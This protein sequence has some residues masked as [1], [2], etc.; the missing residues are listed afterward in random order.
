VIVP[1]LRGFGTTRFLSSE[2]VRNGQQASGTIC[3][4]KPRRP[5]PRLSSTSPKADPDGNCLEII[6]LY[7]GQPN[8]TE[9]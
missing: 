9:T 2:T 1:Y 6:D 3:R 5:L 7:K 4:R 8:T